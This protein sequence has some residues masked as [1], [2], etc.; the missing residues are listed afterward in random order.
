MS[1]VPT[2][3][4]TPNVVIANPKARAVIYGILAWANL[5]VFIAVAVFAFVVGGLASVPV[6][7]LAVQFGLGLLSAGVGFTAQANTPSIGR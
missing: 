2:P 3:T 7:L 5:I 1:N 4:Q 6:W